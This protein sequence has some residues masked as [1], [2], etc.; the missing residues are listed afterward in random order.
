MEER[1]MSKG[2][3]PRAIPGPDELRRRLPASP[4]G[5]AMV[6]RTRRAIRDALRGRDRFRLVVVVGPCSIHDA[7]AAVEYAARLRS[8][9]VETRRELVIVM[10]TYLHKPRT[11]TGWKGILNDPRLDGSCDVAAGL[12]EGRRLLLRIHAQ[13]VPCAAEL[14]DPLSTAYLHDLLSWGAIGARTIQSQVHREMA[15]GL[16]L[17]VGFKN[18]TDGVLDDAA[19]AILAARQPHAFLGVDGRGRVAVMRTRGNPDGHVVLR[20]GPE[21]PNYLPADVAHAASLVRSSRAA[22]PVMVDCSHGNSAK[23]HARQG[24]VCRS[25]LDQVRAGAESILGLLLESNLEAGRQ[26]WRPGAPLRSGISITDACIGFDET[27][28]LL[29]ESASSV[30]ALRGPRAPRVLATALPAG[31]SSSCST[32][33]P[34]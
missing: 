14:L 22:R 9:I 17:P 32:E 25:V 26:P 29:R 13:G 28:E 20:G 27:A 24:A 16:F 30:R 34:A 15:S 2:A 19:H 3:R 7:E 12:E 6:E 10:R 18:G 21:R 11:T 1:S 5:R 33:G 4:Q 31:L 23:D 8:L